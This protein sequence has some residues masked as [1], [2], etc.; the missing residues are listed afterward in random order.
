MDERPLSLN[1]AASIAAVW[2]ATVSRWLR[3]GDLPGQRMPGERGQWLIDPAAL[4][5]FLAHR[6]GEAHHKTT[7]SRDGYL[8]VTQAARI[9]GLS[10]QAVYDRRRAGTL[11]MEEIDG[12]WYV[13]AKELEGN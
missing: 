7:P 2:P 12:Y 1:E 5:A 6:E 9:L 10:R 13:P 8:S 11:R 3:D 4:D